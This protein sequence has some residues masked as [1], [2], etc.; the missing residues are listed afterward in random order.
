MKLRVNKR[1][2]ERKSEAK[3]I[4][5]EGQIPAVIYVKEKASEPITVENAEFGA[6]LRSIIPGRLST[7]IFT[8]VDAKGVERRA[9][10]KE[11]QYE[12]TSY[13]IN[14][15]DF[16][17]L[18]DNQKVT[19]K[20]P[21]ECVGVADC[22]GIKL[23]GV[24]RQVLRYLRVSCLPKDIPNVFQIDIK[25]MAQMETKRLS[26]LQIPQTV[27]PIANLKEVAVVIAKK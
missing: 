3:K 5:R 25:N 23:G 27:R 9:I 12:P 1:S 17:E 7:T 14:H 11:I 13:R 24:L 16:E 8:L 2:A 21:L 6:A 10:V 18:I 20:V 19:V 4:R 22:A 15:L 26:D